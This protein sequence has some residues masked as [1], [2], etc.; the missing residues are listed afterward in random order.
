MG[1]EF[2]FVAAIGLIVFALIQFIRYRDVFHP[3][4]NQAIMVAVL[5]GLR[6]FFILYVSDGKMIRGTDDVGL[7]VP[8]MM[9]YL[10][11]FAQSALVFLSARRFVPFFRSFSWEMRSRNQREFP[12]SLAAMCYM[13][14]NILTLAVFSLQVG[15]VDYLSNIAE[16]RRVFTGDY[17]LYYGIVLAP[18]IATVFWYARV[19]QGDKQVSTRVLFTVAFGLSV[20]GAVLSGFRGVIFQFAITL[21]A[22]RAVLLRRTEYMKLLSFVGLV[23]LLFPVMDAL[24]YGG[25]GPDLLSG[26]TGQL[27]T[28]VS[29]KF[30]ELTLY[31]YGRFYTLEG[32][33]RTLFWL[34]N[35]LVQF[36]HGRLILAFPRILLPT[37]LVGWKPSVSQEIARTFFF[38]SYGAT[39]EI[40]GYV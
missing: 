24:V 12:S 9:F 31:A 7:L 25:F 14:I 21:L 1:K 20:I 13:L 5:L 10:G 23:V 40:S 19:L 28:Y 3:V 2:L 30:Q 4:C 34:G 33:A 15:I 22:L 39:T 27:S 8:A 32:T 35:G 11:F 38:D 26:N 17:T 6:A 29:G 16:V 37:A 18:V 36:D